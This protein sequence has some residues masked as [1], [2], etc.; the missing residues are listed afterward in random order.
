METRAAISGGRAFIKDPRLVP[1]PEASGL[2]DDVIVTPTLEHAL[3]KA[4]KV[5]IRVY[6]AERHGGKRRR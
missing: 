4:G 1:G 3:L 2:A 5:Q 6:G